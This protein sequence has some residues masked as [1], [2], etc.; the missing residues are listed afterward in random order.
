MV[1]GGPGERWTIRLKINAGLRSLEMGWLLVFFF[2]FQAEDGIRDLTVTGVQTCALPI[3]GKVSSATTNEPVAG[4]TVSVVGLPG[5]R[6]TN[7]RGEFTLSAPQ[8]AVTLVVRSVGYK[9]RTVTVPPDQGSVAVSLEQDVFNLEAVVVT[10]QAPG[11]E[12]RNPANGGQ[13]GDAE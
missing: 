10:G 4:A 5:A 7:D 1:V 11:V 8:G 12:Q 3:C 6:V 13:P 2:F 9:H